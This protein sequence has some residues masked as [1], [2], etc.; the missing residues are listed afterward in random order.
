MEKIVVCCFVCVGRK[1]CCTV[2]IVNFSDTQIVVN[3]GDTVEAVYINLIDSAGLN[4]F[5][6]MQVD[7]VDKDIK[8]CWK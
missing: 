8:Q 6:M 4:C 5:K 3:F 7:P 2:F 1:D